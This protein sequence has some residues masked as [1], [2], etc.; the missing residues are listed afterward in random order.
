[1]VPGITIAAAP[2]P[3]PLRYQPAREVAA[4]PVTLPE[5]IRL[6]FGWP[7]FPV[8]PDA[9]S[10][11]QW[12]DSSVP[13]GGE[14][15]RLRLTFAVGD[16]AKHRIKARIAGS[17]EIIGSF[18]ARF[19]Q[20]LQLFELELS[21]GRALAVM[22]E[23]LT[24]RLREPGRPV[25]LLAPVR[26]Q[27]TTRSAT[28]VAAISC[29]P[30][31]QPHL[32]FVPVHYDALAEFRRRLASVVSI[33]PFGWNEGCVLDGLRALARGDSHSPFERARRRHWSL[34][35]DAQGR[36][37]YEN[38]RAGVVRDTFD[39]IEAVLPLADMALQAVDS[40]VVAAGLAF[41]A[42]TRRV[43]GVLQGGDTLS[44]EGSYTMGYPLAV[45]AA[46]RHDRA[47]AGDARRQFLGRRDR[48]WSGNA[49]WLR[50]RDSGRRTFRN[51][52]RGITWHFLGMVRALPYLRQTGIE[53][54]EIETEIRR[55]AQLALGARLQVL[56]PAD[57]AAAQRAVPA[58]EARL[59]PDGFLGAAA[60]GNRGGEALQR[61]DYRVLAAMAMGLFAQALAAMP[62]PS[63][64]LAPPRPA[65]PGAA[66]PQIASTVRP[67]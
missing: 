24:L 17:G 48:L 65:N 18:D 6:P 59:T 67:D 45:L 46:L 30:G 14:T 53:T 58:L 55:I 12:P 21:R 56:T 26:E 37:D 60:Q 22:R 38:P 34:F 66:S 1:M 8:T 35:T 33:A 3:A 42:K 31:L 5:G 16:R 20:A 13:P 49:F 63:A 61:S 64:A 62:E 52:A 23:G 47:Q 19:P 51:W 36:L 10:R 39:G 2:E 54:G 25:W 57:L 4:P 40:P 41:L 9:A 32:L 11:L 27:A 29:P 7:A 43:D 28:R 15:A 44:A 50:H